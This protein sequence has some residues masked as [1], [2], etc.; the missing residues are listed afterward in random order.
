[1]RAEGGT[2]DSVE[3]ELYVIAAPS[4]A[5]KTSLINS[6]LAAF[7]SLAFSVSDTTRPMR[8]GEVDGEHYHFID[9]ATF[10]RRVEQGRYLEHAEVFGNGYGTDRAH[11]ESL[12]RDGKDVLL[13]IDVQG[14]AQVRASQ[15]QACH[16]FILPPSLETL[17]KRLEARGTDRPEV[18]ERRLGEAQREMSFC[19]EFDWIIVNDDFDQAREQLMAVIRAWPLRRARQEILQKAR[20]AELLA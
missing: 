13:E 19:L 9:R 8:R 6:A 10:D 20:M 16:I 15:P 11:V 14:A 12:W 4:G 17:K 18:I 1:M 7:P 5:G 3:G 2:P